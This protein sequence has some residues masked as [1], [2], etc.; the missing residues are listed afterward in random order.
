MQI[1]GRL[2]TFRTFFAGGC[3]DQLKV[4]WPACGVM[5]PNYRTLVALLVSL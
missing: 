4:L 3:L 2:F 1:V 5:Q